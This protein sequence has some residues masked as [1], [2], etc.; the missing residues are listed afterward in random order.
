M[1][2]FQTPQCFQDT[3]RKDHSSAYVLFGFSLNV[4][5]GVREDNRP[6]ELGRIRQTASG[7]QRGFRELFLLDSHRIVI[8][9]EKLNPPP[10]GDSVKPLLRDV[11]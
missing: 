3:P 10:V 7:S 6:T 5:A 4:L 1:Q 11:H 9:M 8:V 2:S